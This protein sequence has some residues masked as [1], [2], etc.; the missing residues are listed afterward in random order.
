MYLT[1]KERQPSGWMVDIMKNLGA[2]YNGVRY[3]GWT[4]RKKRGDSHTSVKF[5]SPSGI[6]PCNGKRRT[7]KRCSEL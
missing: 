2:R 5:V 4:I 3:E 1:N 6:R 7:C